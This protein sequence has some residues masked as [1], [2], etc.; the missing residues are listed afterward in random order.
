MIWFNI[1]E[2]LGDNAKVVSHPSFVLAE[3]APRYPIYFSIDKQVGK[4]GVLSS[5]ISWI[6]LDMF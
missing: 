2:Y 6:S 5:G 3:E 1:I 4:G